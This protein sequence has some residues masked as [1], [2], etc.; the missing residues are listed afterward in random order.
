MKEKVGYKDL[1]VIRVRISVKR[2]KN[3]QLRMKS[4]KGTKRAGSE[5][6]TRMHEHLMECLPKL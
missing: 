1:V 3:I 4:T 6:N 2:A 5:N